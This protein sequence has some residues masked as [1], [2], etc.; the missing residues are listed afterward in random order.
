ML[1]M[2]DHELVQIIA[3]ALQFSGP[4]ANAERLS[5]EAA[6]GR[7]AVV[8]TA[9]RAAGGVVYRGQELATGTAD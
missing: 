7:A 9:L 8:M 1:T 6:H 5:F 2:S 3:R 4:P